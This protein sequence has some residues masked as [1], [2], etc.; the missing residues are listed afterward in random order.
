MK[1]SKVEALRKFSNLVIQSIKAEEHCNAYHDSFGSYSSSRNAFSTSAN[2]LDP[3]D[4]S[5]LGSGWGGADLISTIGLALLVPTVLYALWKSD[6]SSTPPTPEE[7]EPSIVFAK[8]HNATAF[9]ERIAQNATAQTAEPKPQAA[10]ANPEVSLL[11]PSTWSFKATVLALGEIAFEYQK[12]REAE[13]RHKRNAAFESQSW[14][15]R[16]AWRTSANATRESFTFRHTSPPTPGTSSEKNAQPQQGKKT[17]G[18]ESSRADEQQRKNR[19]EKE[20]L[21]K[22][23]KEREAKAKR[24]QEQQQQQKR[25]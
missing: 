1:R 7:K 3:R 24:Q 8:K 12:M 11:S 14:E 19:E 15:R 5:D 2:G 16:N 17:P 10:K 23:R 20:R 22:A 13:E 25:E 21:D 6:T 9:E 18:T 4:S